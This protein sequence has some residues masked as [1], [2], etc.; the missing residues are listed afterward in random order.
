MTRGDT[1]LW[2]EHPNAV[3]PWVL[4]VI[5]GAAAH[6]LT[7][8]AGKSDS[9]REKPPASDRGQA[10]RKAAPHTLR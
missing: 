2:G 10:G 3:W 1:D 5:L 7:D 4:A 8:L 9:E 6:E